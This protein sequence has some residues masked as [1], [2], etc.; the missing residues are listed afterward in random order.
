MLIDS[1]S[2]PSCNAINQMQKDK[3]NKKGQFELHCA[4]NISWDFCIFS[5]S[6][7]PNARNL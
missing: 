4:T 6:G 7:V 1:F 5:R 3:M 2:L